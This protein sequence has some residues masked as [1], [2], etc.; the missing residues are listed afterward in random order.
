MEASTVKNGILIA[1]SVVGSAI[2]KWLGGWDA[3]LA[4]L[5]SLMAIDFITGLMVAF[6]FKR[7][8]KTEGGG[9]SSAASF[10]GLTK[11]IVE[12]VLV[13]VAAM[14]DRVLNVDYART[15]AII[16]YI[17][18]E[19]ISIVENTALMGVPYPAFIRAALEAM[20]EKG[21]KG[22]GDGE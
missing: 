17:G 6:V 11:K 16:F 21:D 15:A 14:L 18:S 3:G 4:V 8:P 5:I 22:G 9:I 2:A 12:L 13:G 7:S 10:K 20:R 19:G 1:L